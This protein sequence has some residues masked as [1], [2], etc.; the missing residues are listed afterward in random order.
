MITWSS[1]IETSSFSASEPNEPLPADGISAPFG[2]SAVC[3]ALGPLLDRRQQPR[4]PVGIEAG[5][6][7]EESAGTE[8]DQ[9]ISDQLSHAIE[10]FPSLLRHE[11]CGPTNPAV[12]RGMLDAV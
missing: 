4:R 7:R 12:R 11:V 8:V 3:P 10:A 1:S 5:I 9:G 6:G 2:F